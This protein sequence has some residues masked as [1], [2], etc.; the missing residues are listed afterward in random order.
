[1]NQIIATSER[2]KSETVTILKIERST[3]KK[4]K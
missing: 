3:K 4:R 2:V 1:M